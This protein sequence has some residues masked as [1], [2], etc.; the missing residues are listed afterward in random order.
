MKK[1]VIFYLLIVFNLSATSTI[2]E[3]EKKL[4]TAE[5]KIRIK[6]C[7]E[8][9]ELTIDRLPETS[10]KYARQALQL[11]K[12]MDYPKCD[13]EASNIIARRHANLGDYARAL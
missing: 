4:K 2:K 12:D 6:L 8:I 7:C 1:V 9:A 10:M 3:L 13:I 5:G 11:A